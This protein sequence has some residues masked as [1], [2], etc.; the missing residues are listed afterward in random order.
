MKFVLEF[1]I[2][3]VR[4][5]RVSASDCCSHF[6]MLNPHIDYRMHFVRLFVYSSH[7]VCTM[8]STPNPEK[9]P[10]KRR[11]ILSVLFLVFSCA[12]T[13]IHTQDTGHL[14]VRLTYFRMLYIFGNNIP[15]NSI[16]SFYNWIMCECGDENKAQCSSLSPSIAGRIV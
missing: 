11:C 5:R 2:V 7:R 1:W 4:R 13:H 10:T 8:R 3:V 12:R 6:S 15:S 14:H 9:W 16:R